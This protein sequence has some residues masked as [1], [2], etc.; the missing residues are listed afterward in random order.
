MSQDKGWADIINWR[1]R[2]LLD[3]VVILFDCLVHIVDVLSDRDFCWYNLVDV[4]SRFI[5][6]HFCVEILLY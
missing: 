4:K 5:L 1:E 2:V 3:E 6:I